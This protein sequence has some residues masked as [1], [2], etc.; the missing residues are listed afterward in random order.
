MTPA[1]E[2]Q[3]RQRD[4]FLLLI[5]LAVAGIYALWGLSWLLAPERREEEPPRPADGIGRLEADL[6]VAER[7][8]RG[9]R[10]AEARRYLERAER[11]LEAFPAEGLRP[12]QRL[13]LE[14]A[15]RRLRALRG[16][17][18]GRDDSVRRGST[19]APAGGD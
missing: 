13:R 12:A 14:R 5:V 7:L 9:G 19:H 17:L 1:R 10:P 3:R 6:E 16:A 18:G 2:E 15:G 11:A 8:A 4:L